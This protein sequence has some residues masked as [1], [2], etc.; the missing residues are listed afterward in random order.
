MDFYYCGCRASACPIQRRCCGG[1]HLHR[2]IRQAAGWCRRRQ[3]CA[4]GRSWAAEAW[5]RWRVRTGFGEAGCPAA[6][7]AVVAHGERGQPC[8]F[9]RLE[10]DGEFASTPKAT[11][12]P[13]DGL[14]GEHRHRASGTTV[15]RLTRSLRPPAFAALLSKAAGVHEATNRTPSAPS[16]QVPSGTFFSSLPPACGAAF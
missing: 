11:S 5:K 12:A 1:G 13:Q 15:S 9:I 7:A 2:Q 3:D 10:M 16:P 4:S 6:S 14:R 8:F